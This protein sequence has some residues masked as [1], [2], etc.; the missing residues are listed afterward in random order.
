M[1]VIVD[2]L[3]KNNESSKKSNVKINGDYLQNMGELVNIVPIDCNE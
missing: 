1:K 2:F 3:G